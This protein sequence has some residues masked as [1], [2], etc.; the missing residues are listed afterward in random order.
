MPRDDERSVHE[1]VRAFVLAASAL[2]NPVPR[3]MADLTA[4][5]DRL[6]ELE[7]D[8]PLVA[9]S[10]FAT[11]PH[12]IADSGGELTYP[13]VAVTPSDARWAGGGGGGGGKGGGEG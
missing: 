3:L 4:P 5:G 12:D 7:R 8:P 9:F 11:L 10:P 2:A 13:P 6:R 1:E